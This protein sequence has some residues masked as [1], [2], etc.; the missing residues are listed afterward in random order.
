MHTEKTKFSDQ[1]ISLDLMVNPASSQRQ[2]NTRQ[3]QSR[4]QEE[5]KANRLLQY[6]KA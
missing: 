2:N 4:S 6:W 3:T 5:A 1:V